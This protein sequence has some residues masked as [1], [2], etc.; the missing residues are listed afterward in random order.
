[1]GLRVF[2]GRQR[3]TVPG[4]RAAR[5]YA[6][7]PMGNLDLVVVTLWLRGAA[8]GQAFGM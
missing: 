3:R 6:G 1:M 5:G 7:E 2:V 4:V 8:N